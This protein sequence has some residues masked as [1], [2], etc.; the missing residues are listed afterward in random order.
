[1][2]KYSSYNRATSLRERQARQK[3]H[4]VW[5]GIGFITM[6]LVPFVS[7]FLM[8]WFLQENAVQHWWAIPNDYIAR[9]GDPYL[10]VKIGVT[11]VISILLYAVVS[12]IGVIFLRVLGKPR[13][14]PLDEPEVDRRSIRRR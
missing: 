5:R 10:Y 12:F 9:T 4:P 13:Y 3:A 11:V 14:G 1:M 8:L 7:Y 6:V 2:G